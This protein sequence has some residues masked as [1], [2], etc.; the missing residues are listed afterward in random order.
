MCIEGYPERN[1]PTILVYKNEDIVRQI[2]T[3]A[4]L[5]GTGTRLEGTFRSHVIHQPRKNGLERI[6]HQTIPFWVLL[7]PSADGETDIEKLLVEVNAI[8]D[9]DQRLRRRNLDDDEDDGNTRK[10]RIQ[11]GNR[12]APTDDNEDDDDW[13]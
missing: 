8:K 12:K 10:T 9:N 4:E 13:D 5:G 7:S 2:V 11:S 1:C 6:Y 3:L